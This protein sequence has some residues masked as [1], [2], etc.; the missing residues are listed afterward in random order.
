M[1]E[2]GTDITVSSPEI[3]VTV[4]TGP[5]LNPVTIDNIPSDITVSNEL[6][7]DTVVT[8]ITV[9][10]IITGQG[11]GPSPGSGDTYFPGIGLETT[12]TDGLITF[13]N[14]GILGV[15]KDGNTYG[16][17]LITLGSNL[18]FDGSV[19]NATGVSST[20][21][22]DTPSPTDGQTVFMLSE[23]PVAL[24]V[25]AVVNGGVLING[26]DFTLSGT[27][28]SLLPGLGYTISSTDEIQFTYEG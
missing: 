24:S 27:T 17:I 16:G 15:V 22:Q 19:L 28:L 3:V 10:T 20:V 8:E 2:I 1:S 5:G 7:A 12:G 9:V 26:L 11:S 25:R 4:T 14:T 21:Y 6:I 18:T 23:M 13:N